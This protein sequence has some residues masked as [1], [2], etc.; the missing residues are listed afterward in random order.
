MNSEGFN[1][2]SSKAQVN[3]QATRKLVQ[4]I[5]EMSK[6]ENNMIPGCK[7]LACQVLT[8]YKVEPSSEPPTIQT[9]FLSPISNPESKQ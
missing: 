4:M 8:V 6:Y 3:S 7:Q 9:P 5:D 2:N 1:A